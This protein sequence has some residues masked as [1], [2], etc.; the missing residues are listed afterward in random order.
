MSTNINI[1]TPT[2]PPALPPSQEEKGARGAG[3]PQGAPSTNPGAFQSGNSANTS[4]ILALISALMK[5]YEY[6]N[7]KFVSVSRV[8]STTAKCFSDSQVSLGNKEMAEMEIQGAFS[9]FSGLMSG[10]LLGL[11][12]GNEA[13]LGGQ[14]TEINASQDFVDNIGSDKNQSLDDV[15]EDVG[16]E[17]PEDIELDELEAAQ[18]PEEN[19]SEVD[20]NKE[21]AKER[22]EEMITE[23]KSGKYK[24]I[25]GSGK[26]AKAADPAKTTGKDSELT[27][28]DVLDTL[29]DE[30][31]MA[32][33]KEA[34]NEHIA[35]KRAALKVETDRVGGLLTKRQMGSQAIDG[36]SK[37]A[38][39]IGAGIE[40]QYQGEQNAANTLFSTAQQGFQKLA[41]ETES[42]ADKDVQTAEGLIQLIPD[43]DKSNNAILTA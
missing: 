33:F 22:L 37:G 24:M 36:V 29:A 40:K 25:E 30:P 43:I 1:K 6:K 15:D 21:K 10:A 7:D 8:E 16:R 42:Q 17:S 27:D 19:E 38:G 32:N 4:A 13:S 9:M 18:G 41:Q 28:K 5:L 23:L 35:N 3:G 31:E 2:P 20:G 12:I 11:Q 34:A 26:S 14:Q 39:G